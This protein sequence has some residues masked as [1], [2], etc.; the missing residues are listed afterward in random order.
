MAS[1]KALAGLA[2]GLSAVLALNGCSGDKPEDGTVTTGTEAQS[3]IVG[4]TDKTTTI[5]PAGSYDKGSFAIQIQVF[6]FLYKFA[7]G[8]KVPVP[9]AAEKCEFTTPIEFTC[10]LKS[11]LKFANGHALTSS[12]VKF[13]FDRVVAID[14]P[15]G[16]ASLLSNLD[17][18]TTPDDLTVVF[19]LKNPNDQTWLQV[20]AT[21]T[22][23]IVDEEV[24]SATDLTPDNDIVAA[25]AFSGPYTITTYRLN[26]TVEFAPYA[27]Y[28][29]AHGTV[30]NGGVTLKTFTDATNLKLSVVGGEI[31]VAY[32]SL[33][34]TDIESL[35]ADSRV[36]VWQE[37]GGEI[38]Y[39]AF[40]FHTQPGDTDEQKFAIRQAV[41][42]LVDRDALSKDI[43]KGQ[44]IPLC[45]Y[46]PLSYPGATTSVCDTYGDKPDLDK[47]KAYLDAAGVA[48]PVELHLQYNPDHYGS[49]SDQEYGLIK[50]Q[51]E[52]S[53]LFT[54]DLQATEW[55]TYVVERRNDAYPVYHMGWF[56]D[57]PDADN[58]LNP[59]FN[60]NSFIGQHFYA[61]EVIDL[62]VA[63]STEVDSAKRLEI[64]KELQLVLAEKYL[65]TLPLLSG[66]QWVVTTAAVSGIELDPSESMAYS[67]ITKA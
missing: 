65:P 32:R 39:I 4:T 12:D 46:V 7:G 48:T 50:Q 63:E 9:D 59:F 35:Q 17:S 30:Q 62:L 26:D 20:L 25:N 45:G 49:S 41:A 8:S 27:D 13:S 11:G 66:S 40:N 16:P 55:T 22:G 10:T 33:T 47:A 23:P 15:Q 18:I 52:S 19:K 24:L 44:F 61:E 6:Q 28:N 14:N 58:F 67:S 3:I 1:K 54:V 31:D 2:I 36:K 43:Y 5:D 51:L 34:P 42:S 29:G 60:E 53:G 21:N 64:L 38:R 37:E 56:P 57:F